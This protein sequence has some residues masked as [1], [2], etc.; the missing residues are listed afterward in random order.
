MRATAALRRRR[1]GQI[2]HVPIAATALIAEMVDLH[3][4]PPVEYILYTD[5][6]SVLATGA[7]A[8]VLGCAPIFADYTRSGSIERPNFPPE[9]PATLSVQALTL[10]EPE[11]IRGKWQTSGSTECI[12]RSRF[13]EV[14]P[15]RAS[16]G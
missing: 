6:G 8:S 12:G 10:R 15:R 4:G 7:V 13:A 14:R 16:P 2:I 9:R 11:K 1:S 3:L 5:Y